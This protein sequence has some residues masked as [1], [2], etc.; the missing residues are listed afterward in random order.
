MRL[1]LK[2]GRRLHE[3]II[4]CKEE[5]KAPYRRGVEK[6]TLLFER[7]GEGGFIRGEPLTQHLLK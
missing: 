3:V 5:E 2:V 7:W 1:L 6:S 4:N